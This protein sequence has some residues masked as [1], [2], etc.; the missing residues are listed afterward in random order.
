MARDV[1]ETARAKRNLFVILIAGG[2]YANRILLQGFLRRSERIARQVLQQAVDLRG[3]LP[4]PASIALSVLSQVS[5]ERNDVA[6]AHQL[7]MRAT[8]VDPNPTSTNAS[9]TTAILRAKI[10]TIQGDTEAALTTLQVARELHSRRPSGVWIDQDLI[11]YQAL[12]RL[13]CSECNDVELLLGEAE[14]AEPHPFSKYVHAEIL[15]FQEQYATAEDV[16]IELITQ[17]PHGFYS[18]PI[19]SSRV[20]LAVAY[21]E[22]KKYNQARQAILEALRSAA[23]EGFIRPFLEQGYRLIPLLN[24]VLHSETLTPEAHAFVKDILRLSVHTGQSSAVIPIENL[25]ALS[26]AASIT[27]R[28]QDVLRMLEAG[29]SN[30]EIA[31]RLSI[32]ESTVKTHL[33]NI[34]YKLG[35]NNRTQA[36]TQARELNL[37]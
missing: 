19:L 33:G 11:A 16:L 25:E 12:T 15:L 22:Q 31:G 1:Y 29:F 5:Y 17:Y 18:E 20:L 14:L 6:R 23:P 34:F 3:T 26:T 36:V 8:E 35:V 10:Q 30:R 21:F 28:E 32:S 2:G 7:L 13:R 37:V 4:E 9:I 24:L 27:S